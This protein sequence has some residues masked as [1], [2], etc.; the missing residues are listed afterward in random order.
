LLCVNP[1]GNA[2]G[3]AIRVHAVGQGAVIASAYASSVL[4]REPWVYT[5]D[6]AQLLAITGP[7]T[8]SATDKPEL[9]ATTASSVYFAA[10]TTQGVE[11]CRV[12]LA[13]AGVPTWN[14]YGAGCPGAAGTP[15]LGANGPPALGNTGFALQARHLVPRGVAALIGGFGVRSAASCGLLVASVVTSDLVFAD[16]LGSFARGLPLPPDPAFAGLTLNFQCFGID[17][18]AARGYSASNGLILVLY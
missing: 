6:R 3:S 5:H 15:W 18:T 13:S 17:P 8:T 16:A 4:G 1:S 14:P 12:P 7:G 9:Y 2:F 11:P 10:V